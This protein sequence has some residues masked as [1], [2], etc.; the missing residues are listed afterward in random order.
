M[1]LGCLSDEG[2]SRQQRKL[3]DFNCSGPW[4]LRMK[5]GATDGDGVYP[6]L[7]VNRSL[8]IIS[9]IFFGYLMLGVLPDTTK[10]PMCKLFI[11]GGE[12]HES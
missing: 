5:F 9:E 4:M 2:L 11:I 1:V 7:N 8:K 10:I 12:Y 3:V 6:R